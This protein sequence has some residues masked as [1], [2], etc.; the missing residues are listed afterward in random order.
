MTAASLSDVLANRV[1]FF[2]PIRQLPGDSRDA[3]WN[4]LPGGLFTGAKPRRSMGHFDNIG[5]RDVLISVLALYPL[6]PSITCIFF[7]IH[8]SQREPT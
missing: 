6:Y 3:T 2:V 1:S 4:S 7:N 8:S 5:G